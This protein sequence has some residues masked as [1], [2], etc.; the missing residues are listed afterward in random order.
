MKIRLIGQRNTT[1]IGT[2]YANFSDAMYRRAG[3][4]HLIEEVNF[5]DHLALSTVDSIARAMTIVRDCY[6][7][8][9]AAAQH[10]SHAVRSQFS[11]TCSV[12]QPLL[13][14]TKLN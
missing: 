2:H 5:C 4:G 10:N 9:Q 7:E 12:D 3:I 1:G 14:L 8:Y 13:A 11:W 6:P